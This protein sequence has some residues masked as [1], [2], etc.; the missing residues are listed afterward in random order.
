MVDVKQQG[1]ARYHLETLPDGRQV[2]VNNDTGMI[3]VT[4]P[5]TGI[6]VREVPKT[7]YPPGVTNPG[8]QPTPSS[9]YQPTPAPAGQANGPVQYPPGV[10][11]PAP[12]PSPPGVYQ[13]SPYTPGGQPAPAT[14]GT[15]YP[16]G[17]TNAGGGAPPAA[18]PPAQVVELPQSPPMQA[19]SVRPS[20]RPVTSS[21]P[22]TTCCAVGAT[23]AGRCSAC[24]RSRC[25]TPR[26]TRCTTRPIRT[27]PFPRR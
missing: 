4:D 5:A 12:R 17:V 21:G 2:M 24:S 22:S 6:I 20:A 26:S 19:S 23:T 25:R 13:P 15:V 18:A 7:Q 1:A 10:T 27:P 3:A 8:P 16:K 14:G 11:N 9:I